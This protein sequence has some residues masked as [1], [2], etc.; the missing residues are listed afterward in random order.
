MITNPFTCDVYDKARQW[1]GRI[2]DPVAI[3]G[4]VKHNAL[5]GFQFR[6]KA[7]DPMTEDILTHGARVGITYRG[8]RLMSGAVRTPSGSLGAGGDI[9][10]Q[11]QDDWRM[12][13]NTIAYVNPLNPLAPTTLEAAANEAQAWLPGGYSDA[14]PDGTTQGQVGYYLWPDGSAASGGVVVNTAEAAV[15][16]LI[17][18]NLG[19]RL[20]LPI[21]V[22][23]DLARGGDARAAGMLPP[24]RMAKVSEAIL[25]LLNW[26]GM[27]LSA[28]Q[29][30]GSDVIE[31][32]TYQPNIWP[33]ELTVASG[34]VSA[35]TWTLGNPNATRS[36]VG[37]PGEGVNRAFW[38]VSDSTGLEAEYGDIIEV[39]RDATGATLSWPASLTEAYKVA[40]YF[41][42]RADIPALD[43]SKFQAYLIAA[44][45]AGLA[46]GVPTSSVTATLSETDSFHF[47]GADGVGLGDRITIKADSGALFTDVIT[48]AKFSLTADK[49]TVEPILGTKTDDPAR[50]LADAIT[51]LATAQRK[52]STS[53]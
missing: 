19:N 8:L 9:V 47:G 53:R 3:D 11:V 42:L 29:H 40:K 7:S 41:L 33:A 50:Q 22:A 13:A 25:P 27:G 31:F 15:K 51:R 37:G 34:I 20:G 17:R 1:V 35:G 30:E 26:S 6:I 45:R 23:A 32:D 18:S 4:S 46:E 21:T 5:G 28:L 24:V 12:L 36:V 14:G 52:L 16:H 48:E 44:G 2:T 38:G 43:K 39:F 10:F 49:L